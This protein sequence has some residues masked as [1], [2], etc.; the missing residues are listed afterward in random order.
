MRPIVSDGVAWSVS[1]SVCWSVSQSVTIFSRAK[2]AQPIEMLF[3]YGLG[4]TQGTVCKMGIQIPYAKGQ[5]GG[6]K[7][8]LH[9]ICLT[10][11]TRLTI[12]LQWNPSFGETQV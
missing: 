7:R 1:L 2:T 9:G 11:R 4:W 8:Y 6:G 5:F 12:L 10:E 3:G